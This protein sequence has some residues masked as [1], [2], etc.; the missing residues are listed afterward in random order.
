MGAYRTGRPYVLGAVLALTLL[1]AVG[2]PTMVSAGLFSHSSNKQSKSQPDSA[3]AAALAAQ[4]EQAL[5]EQRD[6]DAGNLLDEAATKDLKSPALTRLGGELLL[7]RGNYTDAL[8]VFRIVDNNPAEKAKALEGEGI[9]LSLLGHSDD[10]LAHLKQAIVL[11]KNL[12]RAWNGLGRE[13]DLRH[14]WTASADA[15]E[16]ALAAPGANTAVVLNNRGYSRMLQHRTDLAATDFVNAL[17]KDPSLAPART[18]LRMA[19]AMQGQYDRAVMTGVGDDRAAVLNNV[20]LAAAMRGDYGEADKLF[21]D[22]IAAKGQF[23][24]RAAANLALSHEMAARKSQT[25]GAA[26]VPR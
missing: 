22:A 8:D 11:D 23:Y 24:G 12:W 25:A 26:D 21:G 19:L 4:V 15:Y 7:A 14:D 16:H 18:N 20:G 5:D 10:A 1:G 2:S 3:A 13:Y 17:Q 6:V 9:A